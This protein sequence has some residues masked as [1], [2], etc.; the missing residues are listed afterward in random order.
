MFG[1]PVA[2]WFS[3]DNSNLAFVKF[4]DAEVDF[5]QWPLYGEP[6]VRDTVYPKYE[7]IRY[8]K[9]MIDVW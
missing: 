1:S 9:V 6:G 4:D 3:T 5:Y 2:M 8:P 7:P